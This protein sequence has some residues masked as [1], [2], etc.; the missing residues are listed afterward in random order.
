MEI[1]G[2]KGKIQ[3]GRSEANSIRCTTPENG[4]CIQFIDSWMTLFADA[5]LAEDISFVEAILND[6]QPAVTGKDGREAVKLVEMG[7]LSIKTKN[8]VRL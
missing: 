6:T 7:N 5:Y 2:T 1:I 3:V 4:T 8:I